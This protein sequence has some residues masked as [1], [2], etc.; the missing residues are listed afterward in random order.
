MKQTNLLSSFNST[1]QSLLFNHRGHRC[2]RH[3]KLDDGHLAGH[4]FQKGIQFSLP[5]CYLKLG[6]EV[7]LLDISGFCRCVVEVFA[8][9]G[10]YALLVIL[11]LY[12]SCRWNPHAAP[13]RR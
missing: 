10:L 11:G 9:R 2:F 6:T 5:L 4:R 7:P 1:F 3:F 8:L 12:V 13:K